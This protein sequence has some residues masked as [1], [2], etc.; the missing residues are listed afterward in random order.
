MPEGLDAALGPDQLKDLLT[1]LLTSPLEPAPIDI[2]G[3]PAARTMAEV[4]AILGPKPV[5]APPESNLAALRILLCDGP[6]DHGMNE[7]DY[8]LWQERWAQL[9]GLAPEVK[10]AIAHGFPTPEAMRQADVIVFFS[11]NPGWSAEKGND[12]RQFQDRGGGLVYLHFAVDGHDAADSLSRQIGLAW[13]AGPARFRHGP[14]DL[15]F[16]AS[17]SIA[18]GFSHLH[19]YDESYWELQGDE[20]SIHLVASGVEDGRPRPLMWTKENGAGRVFVSIPGHFTWTFDDPL[21]RILI[22]RGICWVA[23]QPED[24]LSEL[25]TIGARTFTPAEA[26]GTV[27]NVERK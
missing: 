1:F 15:A 7:H 17:S 9:L 18:H 14:L 23:H 11:D 19:L 5:T 4:A 2:P 13:R 24:R 26:R 12:L 27:A 3:I 25:A 22:L 8:P 20:K 16:D 10:V 21:F 6:K